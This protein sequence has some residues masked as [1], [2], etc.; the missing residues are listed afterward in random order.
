MV[1]IGIVVLLT[2]GS[3]AGISA[4]RTH[5]QARDSAERIKSFLTDA[6][7]RAM[8]PRDSDFNM[9]YIRVRIYPF[10]STDDQNQNKILLYKLSRDIPTG[11]DISDVRIDELTAIRGTILDVT[12]S[13]TFPAEWSVHCYPRECDPDIRRTEKEYI[14]Y[15]YVAGDSL[16]LGQILN[17][18]ADPFEPA[19]LKVSESGNESF[20]KDYYQ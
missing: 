5:K 16:F 2:A 12:R 14:Y 10:D 6:R 13:K 17:G 15:D 18:L 8:T 7:S 19:K 9:K 3:V 1:V 11:E 4:S 20:Q